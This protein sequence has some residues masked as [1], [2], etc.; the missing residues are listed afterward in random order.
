MAETTLSD[1]QR[2]QLLEA[3]YDQLLEFFPEQ[4]TELALVISNDE[5]EEPDWSVTFNSSDFE[6][7][8]IKTLKEKPNK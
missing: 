4:D 6:I 5:L 1:D 7:L 8:L 2:K 3:I